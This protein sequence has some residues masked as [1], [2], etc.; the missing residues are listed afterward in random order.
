MQHSGI[1][2][3]TLNGR[4]QTRTHA[5]TQASAHGATARVNQLGWPHTRSG[6]RVCVCGCARLGMAR[7]SVCVRVCPSKPQ[8]RNGGVWRVHA[9]AHAISV[10]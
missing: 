6:G 10:W 8:S 1:G 9:G 4:T 5:H 3:R 7:V 2:A